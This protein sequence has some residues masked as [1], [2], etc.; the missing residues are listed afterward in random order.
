M[1]F[2]NFLRISFVMCLMFIASRSNAQQPSQPLFTVVNGSLANPANTNPSPSVTLPVLGFALDQAG[3]LRPLIGITGAASVGAP[4]AL[5]LPIVQAAVPANHD[6]ILAMTDKSRWPV[7]LQIRGN[8]ITVLPAT[9]F[10][11][12][13]ATRAVKCYERNS[14]DDR[15]R[16]GCERESAAVE[17]PSGVDSIAVSPTGSVAGLF[18]Q[19][20]GRIYAFGN[21][22]KAPQLLGT[23]E[24]AGIGSVSAFGISDDGTTVV[25]AASSPNAGSLYLINLGQ[26][27]RIIGSLQHPAAVQFLRNN[28]GAIVA[29]DVANK[30]YQVTNGQIVSIASADD[31]IATPTSIGISNDNQKVF[32]G[33]SASGAVTTI[34]LSGGATQSIP[35]NC[36]L[37][38]LQPTSA[39]SVFQ[40]TGFSGGP[41]LLFDGSSAT[42]RTIFV[43]VRAQY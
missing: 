6:Y 2:K 21:L 10:L 12:N 3:G 7:L 30:I 13:T 38:G 32:V 42:A 23:F 29:D 43:P 4:I 26:A 25:A 17:A 39:D 14:F 11:G 41:I 40:L 1:M 5:Q 24:T 9:S 36:A 37:T 15:A 34:S 19:D 28:A 18:S 22:A 31:G 35:C 20:E 27:P 33:N 16:S 8:T